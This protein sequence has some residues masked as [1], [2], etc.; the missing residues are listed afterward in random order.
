MFLAAHGPAFQGRERASGEI[1]L[2]SVSLSVC[3]FLLPL[4]FPQ[5]NGMFPSLKWTGQ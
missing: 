2:L 5:S 4:P 1:V 3:P